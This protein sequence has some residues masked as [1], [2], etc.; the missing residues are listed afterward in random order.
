MRLL[1]LL[2]LP[3]TLFSQQNLD[4]EVGMLDSISKITNSTNYR[5]DTLTTTN[6]QPRKHIGFK[7]TP[8]SNQI[9]QVCKIYELVN[10]DFKTTENNSGKT[11]NGYVLQVK[12]SPITAYHSYYNTDKKLIAD[13]LFQDNTLKVIKLYNQNYQLYEMLFLQEGEWYC[14]SL[15]DN[16]I[17]DKPIYCSKPDFETIFETL[18]P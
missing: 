12:I 18:A 2:L 9:D 4:T 8:Y 5:L 15:S 17:L 13:L 14:K 3:T 10:L 6:P 11:P 16:W 7:A 1:F